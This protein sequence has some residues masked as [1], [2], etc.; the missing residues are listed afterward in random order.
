MTNTVMF[1]FQFFHNLIGN[2]E[3]STDS[4]TTIQNT[5]FIFRDIENNWLMNQ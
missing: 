3:Q 4:I 1:S 2:Y 5:V